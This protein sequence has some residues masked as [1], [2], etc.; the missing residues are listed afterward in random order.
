ME[1]VLKESF[2][3]L[4]KDE[5]PCGC[6]MVKAAGAG[7]GVFVFTEHVSS[8]AFTSQSHLPRQWSAVQFSLDEVK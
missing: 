6:V 5:V 7:M 1:W 3:E 4:V 2:V 8:G